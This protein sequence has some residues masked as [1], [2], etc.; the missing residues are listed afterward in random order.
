MSFP[1]KTHISDFQKSKLKPLLPKSVDVYHLF[2][3]IVVSMMIEQHFNDG[4]LKYSAVFMVRWKWFEKSE[5]LHKN[6]NIL[7]HHTGT[8]KTHN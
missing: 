3:S 8:S 4:L 1:D 7:V 6:L 2:K 5:N